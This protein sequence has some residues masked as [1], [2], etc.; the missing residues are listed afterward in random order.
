MCKYAQESD[1]LPHLEQL[2][3]AL[4]ECMSGRT[5]DGKENAVSALVAMAAKCKARVSSDD[6]MRNQ[7]RRKLNE[8]GRVRTCAR[9]RD[10]EAGIKSD[11][12]EEIA[13]WKHGD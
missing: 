6:T 7:V 10:R 11:R 5:W 1:L 3:S 12:G 9:E 8:T 13:E 4:V 2:V